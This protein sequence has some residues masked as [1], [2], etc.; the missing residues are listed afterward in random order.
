MRKAAVFGF[1]MLVVYAVSVQP[2]WS[3]TRE[4]RVEANPPPAP[5]AN[6][7]GPK[8]K[9]GA[10]VADIVGPDDEVI[11]VNTSLVTVP[12]SVL[13]RNGKYLTDL[14]KEDFQLLEDGAPQEIAYFAAIEKPVAVIL[15]IDTST[16]TWSKLSEI[17]AAANAFVEQLRP[18]DSVMVLSFARNV[19]VEG[20]LTTDRERI[21]RAINGTGKGSST[22][23]YDA[24]DKV[25]RK[26]LASIQGRKALVLFT[27]GVDATSSDSTYEGTLGYAQEFDAVIYPI[28]YDTYDPSK[29]Q[30]GGAQRMRLPGILGKLPISIRVGGGS[31]GGATGY[32]RAEYDRGARYLDELADSTGGRVYE[33]SRDLS[34][35][36]SAFTLI[37]DELARQYTL[38]YYPKKNEGAG[39]RRT[40]KVGVNRTAVAIRARNSYVF[41]NRPVTKTKP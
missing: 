8:S 26:H 11:R 18:E 13:D 40:I 15:M 12:V 7:E 31:G 29:D 22:H 24:M 41:Q 20:E 36:R 21:R 33:A 23:L 35:L 5:V 4:R 30:G 2:G 3:Q 37:A 6:A 25:M 14:Q 28:R 17:K 19:T 32:S 38:G 10:P 1:V 34:Q 9:D 39:E 27:D 16:S